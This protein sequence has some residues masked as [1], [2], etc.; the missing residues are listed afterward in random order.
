MALQE[1]NAWI[2]GVLAVLAYGTY[3]VLL[4]TGSEPGTPLE[5][6]PFAWPMI[7]AIAGSIVVSILLNI[8]ASIGEPKGA[9]RVDQRDRQIGRFGEYTGQS[10]LVLG[11]IVALALTMLGAAHFWIANAIFLG[12]VLSAV[13]GSIAK[14]AV[15][16]GGLPEW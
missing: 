5:Q 11:S 1:K 14:I 10:L 16:R 12:F 2:L 9:E 8:I 7:W 3:L 4:S 15:Y 13:L 6:R